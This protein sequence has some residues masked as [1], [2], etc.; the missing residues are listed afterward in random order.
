MALKEVMYFVFVGLALSMYTTDRF[1]RK[2]LLTISGLGITLALAILGMS[3]SLMDEAKY[4]P[5]KWMENLPIIGMVIYYFA[6]PIGFGSVAYVLL[7][8]LFS[9]S[10]KAIGTSFSTIVWYDFNL[11]Y[12]I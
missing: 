7:G 4:V 1:G 2:L 3:F 5:Y 12:L 9:P 10:I 8:E 6:F 11:F